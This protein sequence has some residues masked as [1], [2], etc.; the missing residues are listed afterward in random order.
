MADVAFKSVDGGQVKSFSKVKLVNMGLRQLLKLLNT[1]ATM[2]IAVRAPEPWPSCTLLSSVPTHDPMTI[3]GEQAINQ[4][5]V[6]FCVVPVFPIILNGISY[7]LKA[8][9]VPCSSTSCIICCRAS[10]CSADAIRTDGVLWSA[11]YKM[12]PSSFSTRSIM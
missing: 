12:V 10:T 3:S 6:L 9:P 11:S 7:A 2:G 5:S 1:E 8:L 4:P